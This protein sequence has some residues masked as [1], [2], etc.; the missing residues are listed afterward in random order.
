VSIATGTDLRAAGS[1]Y[2]AWTS[3]YLQL[4]RQLP[5]RV[6]QEAR[7]IT[8]NAE[9]AY[10]RATAIESYLRQFRYTTRVKQP[11]PDRDWVDYML[12]ES[13]EGYCDYYATAM[14]TML[15]AIGIPARVASGFAPGDRDIEQ[16]FIVV[17]E[18]HAHSWT[19]A[20]FPGY[21]WITFE[22]SALRPIP[23]RPESFDL[24][25]SL[26]WDLFGLEDEP[27][28]D[29]DLYGLGLL[30][31]MEDEGANSGGGG[32]PGIVTL[33]LQALGILLSV[34]LLLSLTL[35]GLAIVWQR[36]LRSLR[37]HVR[38]YAQLCALAGWAGLV[39]QPG[40]TPFEYARVL[41]REIPPAR[42]GLEA[43]TQV[44]VRGTYGRDPLDPREAARAAQAWLGIRWLLAKLLVQR[45]WLRFQRLR[46][47]DD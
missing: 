42:P 25:S 45:N 32:F 44:Y 34:L 29:L 30:D 21:G 6:R 10:D 20:Y 33:L 36:S 46:R 9:N 38:P 41:A 15:R 18:S 11:P 12:F 27:E 28:E 1:D 26:A 13:K 14:A 17:K 2:P 23:P 3:R 19:E 5:A 37:E 7:R 43:I 8:A 31:G 40:D 35:V 16:D 47:R 4:P 39:R 22:P 24:D